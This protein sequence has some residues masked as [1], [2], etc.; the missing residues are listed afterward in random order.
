MLHFNQIS[1]SKFAGLI[2]L[3]VLIFVV[4]RSINLL[5]NKWVK[6]EAQESLLSVYVPITIN[7]VWIFFILYCIY[8]LAIINPLVS[9]FISSLVLLATWNYVKDF[10]QGTI[11]KVQKGNLVGQLIN[12]NDFSGKVVKMKN[13]R[14]YLQIENG[15]IIEYPYSKL[16]DTII[17]ISSN[18]E[19]YKK[20]TLNISVPI[21]KEIEEIKRQLRLQLFNIPW[22]VSN[23]EIKIDIIS[24]DLETIN[25]KISTYTLDEKFI[26]K[27]QQIVD[28][29]KFD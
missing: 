1:I 21:T 24:Q 9:V 13:T 4:H 16:S 11:F 27:I 6:K 19:D 14:I 18:V 15:E 10:V 29:I 28:F 22:I 8:L 12:V 7:F 26:P 2:I 23:Q 3:A 25:F 17:A 5:I 20:C